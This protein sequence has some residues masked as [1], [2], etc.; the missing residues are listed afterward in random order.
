MQNAVTRS[1]V[2]DYLSSHPK[3]LE[4]LNTFRP[5]TRRLYI[6]NII[7]F[8]RLSNTPIEDLLDKA[9]NNQIKPVLIR[10][11]IISSLQNLTNP[12]QVMTDAAVRSFLKYWG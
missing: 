12:N 10:S 3:V 5:P 11:L 6:R 1:V 4:W 7:T 8:E 2:E 9:E